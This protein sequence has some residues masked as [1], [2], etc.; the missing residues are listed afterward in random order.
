MHCCDRMTWVALLAVPC[1][2]GCRPSGDAKPPPPT[3][4]APS[5]LLITLDTTRADRIGAYGYGEAVTPALDS[6]AASGTLFEHAFAQVPLTLPSHGSLLSG[7]Y[8]ATNGTRI[9]GVALNA[10]G[11]PLLAQVFQDHGYRTGAFVSCV[12]LESVFGL[13]RGF[14]LY[15]DDLGDPDAVERPANE[16]SDA[17]LAWLGQSEKQ[18]F[19]AWVHFYDPHAPYEPPPEY[20][21]ADVSPYDGEIAFVDAQIGRLVRW[22][23]DHNRLDNT[24]IIVAGDHGESLGEHGEPQHGF[25]VYDSTMRVPLVFTFPTKIP[26]GVSISEVV[27]LVDAYP[28]I[29]ELLE[30]DAPAGLEGMSLTGTWNGTTAESSAVYGETYYPRSAFGW[31]PL[32]SLVTKEWKYVA[33]PRPELYDRLRDAG[34]LTNVLAE[35]PDVATRLQRELRRRKARMVSRATGKTAIN[36]AIMSRLES[37][38]YVAAA[39]ATEDDA[40]AMRRP[41]PKDMLG[42]YSIYMKATGR[43]SSKR[44]DEVISLLEPLV[45]MFPEA[46]QFYV[47][48]GQA[49]LESGRAADAQRAFETSLQLSPNNARQLWRL[50]KALHK[51]WKFDDAV[52]AFRAALTI[53]PD[54]A[55]A[56]CSLGDAFGRLGRVPEAIEHFAAA[57]AANPQLA[58]AHGRLGVAYA[59]QQQFAIALPHLQRYVEL[60]PESPHALSNLGN[61][62]VGMGRPLEATEVL[63]KAL[64]YDPRYSPAHHALPQALLAARMPDEALRAL[65]TAQ[66]AFPT[67]RALKHQLARLLATIPLGNLRDT[68]EAVR[69]AQELCEHQD[70]SSDDLLLLA[71]ACA[72]NGDVPCADRAARD[73]RSLA[74]ARSEIGKAEQAET[75]LRR[76]GVTLQPEP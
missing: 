12:V 68:V 23:D 56:H 45:E 40:A 22:L 76:L 54:F 38:G 44:F 18:P 16:V 9:N 25:F 61:V 15:D 66:A 20:A 73:A 2:W 39:Q 4:N 53:R 49:Y 60:E 26:A 11:I 10:E 43:F 63:R 13:D 41:D 19:F 64:R 5:V 8:P 55:M 72:S 70:R 33:A 35:H 3:A 62:L 30:W 65:R 17:A 14:D 28:T 71:I 27:G 1:V 42:P 32:R 46:D 37:L 47:T 6:L 7:T 59:K 34:E 51:Q 74:E 67:D 36:P 52:A 69:L 75:L 21:S 29:M 50:G 58:R 57:V 48:L 24:L 31:A